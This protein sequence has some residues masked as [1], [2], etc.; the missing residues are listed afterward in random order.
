MEAVKTYVAK[1]IAEA[2]MPEATVDDVDFQRVSREG[3]EYTAKVSVSNPY[4]TPLPIC[5]ISYSLKSD[6]REIASGVI[7]DPGSLKAKG[8]TVVEVPVKVAHSILLSLGRDV[9]KDWDIDYKLDLV[10][11]I[12]LPVIGNINIP[13]SQQGEIKLPT[14]SDLFA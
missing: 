1:K 8:S 14:L 9:A 10:F 13:V 12:D 3:V 11:I 5:E 6:G 2:P 4:P 7:P